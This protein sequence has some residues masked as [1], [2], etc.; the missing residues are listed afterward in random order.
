MH[1]NTGRCCSCVQYIVIC[2][3]GLDEVLGCI[4]L[5]TYLLCCIVV[6]CLSIL[7]FAEIVSA[8]T[9]YH[10]KR[11]P[12]SNLRLFIDTYV[13]ETRCFLLFEL[14]TNKS[15]GQNLS[16]FWLRS[17]EN[18]RRRKVRIRLNSI[19]Q[20]IYLYICDFSPILTLPEG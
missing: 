4:L 5:W 15:K 11:D 16:N 12:R 2:Y 10:Q 6:L 19:C 14:Q 1:G 18:Q 20:Q 9:K 7:I 3:F 17:E 13:L 8:I